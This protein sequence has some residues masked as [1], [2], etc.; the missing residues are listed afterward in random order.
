LL[1]LHL[2]FR[3]SPLNP[4]SRYCQLNLMFHYYLLSPMFPM[5]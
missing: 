1:L 5:M 4:M 2:M 3:M